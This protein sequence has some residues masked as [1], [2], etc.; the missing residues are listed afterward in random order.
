MTRKLSC[1]D[2]GVQSQGSYVH[3]LAVSFELHNCI[4]LT[5]SQLIPETKLSWRGKLNQWKI[6]GNWAMHT[7]MLTRRRSAS[8]VKAI[9]NCTQEILSY[10]TSPLIGQT[11]GRRSFRCK[12]PSKKIRQCN[13]PEW[14]GLYFWTLNSFDKGGPGVYIFLW[15]GPANVI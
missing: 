15:A 6:P 3:I 4:P 2:L 13:G 9:P 12:L 8:H 10:P 7:N 5:L 11:R 14:M 1:L